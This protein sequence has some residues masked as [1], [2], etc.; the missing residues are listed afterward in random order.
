MIFSQS[1]TVG[2]PTLNSSTIFVIVPPSISVRYVTGS[3]CSIV[4]VSVSQMMGL[5]GTVHTYAT[6]INTQLNEA[7]KECWRD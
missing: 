7:A 6:A 5:L 1:D 2:F 4:T 3:S